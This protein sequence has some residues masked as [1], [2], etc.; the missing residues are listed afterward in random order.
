[1]NRS[2]ASGQGVSGGNAPT[3]GT[4]TGGGAYSTYP[5]KYSYLPGHPQDY[6]YHSN[7]TVCEDCRVSHGK[8]IFLAVPNT[9]QLNGRR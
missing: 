7:N 9:K 3:T 5:C 1:M 4:G 6:V 2:T 8:K